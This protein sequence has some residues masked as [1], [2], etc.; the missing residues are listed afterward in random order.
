MPSTH[1]TTIRR[2]DKKWDY[3]YLYGYKRV[4][5]DSTLND[6]Y[7]NTEGRKGI[8]F[9]VED[10]KSVSKCLGKKGNVKLEKIREEMKKMDE[11][12]KRKNIIDLKDK[13]M[14]DLM[15]TII[16]IHP[17]RYLKRCLICK[18]KWIKW[19]DINETCSQCGSSD[20][21]SQSLTNAWIKDETGE[22]SLDLWRGNSTRFKEGDKINLI[23]C[24]ARED[25]YTDKKGELHNLMVI[26]TGKNG[27]IEKV[28]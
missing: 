17:I 6:L 19:E 8:H 4:K 24:F 3:T 22:C 21:K 18:N 10:T 23:N 20:I 1:I 2:D 25:V 14:V 27:S 13:Q 28:I 5:R 15:A 16:K 11:L 26:T 7:P 9:I 12:Q